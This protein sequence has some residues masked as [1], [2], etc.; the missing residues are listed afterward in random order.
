MN[1]PKHRGA[2]I[3]GLGET[4]WDVF[5]DGPRF[6]GA[7]A[8]FACS[9]AGLAGVDARVSMV[10]GVGKDELGRQALSSFSEHGVE[11]SAVLQL[12]FPTG[13]VLVQLEAQGQAT[14]E[15]V[16]GTAWDHLSWTTSMQH[17]AASADAVCFGTLGQRSEPSREVIQRFLKE[18]SSDCLRVFDVNLRPP[19]WCERSLLQSLPL[20]NVLKCNEEELPVLSSLLDIRGDDISRLQQLA[21]RYAYQMVVLTRGGRWS[22]LL[23]QRGE[24]SEQLAFDTAVV[25]T[26]GA[27]DSF[28]AAVV[29]GMLR[30]MPLP[31]IHTWANRVSAFVCSR[32]GATPS[33]PGDLQQA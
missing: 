21:E 23:D 8:N 11:T 22:L 2:T 29:L 17:L 30:K 31:Q 6:G 4:L 26:V 25:D 7:P 5:P 33:I 18:A 13:Q 15:F 3:V 27:G 28:T 19:Y 1:E 10:S 12:P 24:S 16:S 9:A 32:S 14:Y 20:A